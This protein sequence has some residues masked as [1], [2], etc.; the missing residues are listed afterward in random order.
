LTIATGFAVAIACHSPVYAHAATAPDAPEPTDPKATEQ[1]DPVPAL[2][3]PGA[4]PPIKLQAHGDPS[5]PISF[6]NIWVRKLD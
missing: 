6:R 2:V 5:P 4:T 1:W 3:T